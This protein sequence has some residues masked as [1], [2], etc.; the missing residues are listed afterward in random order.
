MNMK[1]FFGNFT[2]CVI[3]AAFISSCNS[4]SNADNAEEIAEEETTTTEAKE[5]GVILSNDKD[6]STKDLAWKDLHGRVKTIIHSQHSKCLIEYDCLGNLVSYGGY[7]NFGI[8]NIREDNPNFSNVSL[9]RDDDGYIV[10]GGTW[11]GC[12]DWTWENGRLIKENGADESYF[13]EN[14]YVYNDEGDQIEVRI[15]EGNAMDD[16]PAEA[17]VNK[18]T[19]TSRDEIG[20]WTAMTVGTD[21]MTRDITYY[22]NVC[23][24]DAEKTPDEELGNTALVFFGSIGTESNCTLQAIGKDG[25]YYLRSGR[26][27]AAFSEYKD[28]TLV[29]NAFKNNTTDKIGEFSGTFN[30]KTGEYVG[31]FTNNAGNSISFNLCLKKQ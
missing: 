5:I 23:L 16:E 25:F 7:N 24:F 30:K 1:I 8:E 22:D 18:V 19:I 29:I 21:E 28:G 17:V 10:H 20:N 27:S 26:R 6:F 12:I 9:S 3:L 4:N 13:W 11:E 31:K 2:L 14:E 15:T